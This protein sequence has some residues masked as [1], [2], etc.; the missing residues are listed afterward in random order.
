MGQRE[1][2]WLSDRGAELRRRHEMAVV[3]EGDGRVGEFERLRDGLGDGRERGFGGEGVFE[4]FSEAREDGV[5]IVA[6]TVH[7]AVHETL[8]TIA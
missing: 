3:F 2:N 7:E 4:A 5:W 8:E 6:F 1:D